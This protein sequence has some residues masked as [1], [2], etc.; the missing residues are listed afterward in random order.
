MGI[1]VVPDFREKAFNLSPFNMLAVGLLY[2]VFMMLRYVF[3]M[4]DVDCFA[5]AF[6]AFIEMIMHFVLY[7]VDVVYI[8]FIDLYMLNHSCI[9]GMNPI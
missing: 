2:M 1:L 4:K 9:P 8:T 7:S 5:N 3:I 6:S